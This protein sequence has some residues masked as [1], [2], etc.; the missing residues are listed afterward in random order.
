M[1]TPLNDQQLLELRRGQ[2][3]SDIALRCLIWQL[4]HYRRRYIGKI[5]SNN[6]VDYLRSELQSYYFRSPRGW[7]RQFRR[8]PVRL[9]NCVYYQIICDL[10]GRV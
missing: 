1:S 10:R 2:W 7:Q 4:L 5:E 9:A 8:R 3:C 6:V